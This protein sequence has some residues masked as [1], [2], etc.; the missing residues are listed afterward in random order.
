MARILKII[1]E[2]ILHNM[3]RIIYL[4][5]FLPLFLFSC[6][7]SPEAYFY[8]NTLEP[9]VGQTVDFINDSHDARSFE[10]DFGDGTYSNEDSPSHIFTGTGTFE[11]TLKAISKN[12]LE[13]KA[14]LTLD[15]KIPTLLEIEVLEYYDQ[16]SVAN[17]S[18]ILYPLL[19]DWVAQ[20]NKT[21]EGIT[22]AD[23]I[24]VFS[25][26]DPF[27]YYV[28][29]WELHHDN[30]TLKN[31]DVGFIRTPEILAH[32]INRFVAWV[33]Y[34]EVHKGAGETTRTAVI[35]KLERKAADKFQPVL[36]QGTEGWQELY[37]RRAGK[38]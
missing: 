20:T 22:D 3:K 17:A 10:W 12:G 24:V 26:L 31:E 25:N 21:T 27:V 34:V 16:Y 7:K 23:G 28:D 8:T 14:K 5:L 30:W 11:V 36:D 37:N 1:S 13:D 38:K 2:L 15:V 6:Q 19:T 18:V 29:V 35:R 9:E 4:T 32:K 33:D